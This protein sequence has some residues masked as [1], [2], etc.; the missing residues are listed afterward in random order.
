MTFILF[1]LESLEI[2]Y[3]SV[4]GRLGYLIFVIKKNART[5]HFFLTNL[6]E[7]S[8]KLQSLSAQPICS[9][10]E[11]FLMEHKVTMGLYIFSRSIF[12]FMG[13]CFHKIFLKFELDLTTNSVS[14]TNKNVL[15]ILQNSHSVYKKMQKNHKTTI[16]NFLLGLMNSLIVL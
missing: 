6:E 2:N 7:Q 9:P 12:V 15:F 11:I 1:S 10:T 4:S 13:Q 5:R 3:N 8:K 16:W 14:S